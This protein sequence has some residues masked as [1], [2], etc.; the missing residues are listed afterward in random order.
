MQFVPLLSR[1]SVRVAI[2]VLWAATM[3]GGLTVFKKFMGVLTTGV[4]PPTSS[5]SAIAKAKFA[6]YFPPPSIQLTALVRSESGEPL[7]NG[8][9][10]FGSLSDFNISHWPDLLPHDLNTPL[11]AAAAAIS[12]ALRDISATVRVSC[13]AT[14]SSFWDNLFPSH[15]KLEEAFGLAVEH[16]LFSPDFASTLMVTTI[17]ACHGRPV[18]QT[19]VTDDEYCKPIAD[20][21]DALKKYA[22][23]HHGGALSVEGAPSLPRPLPRPRPRA[24]PAGPPLPALPAA[25]PAPLRRRRV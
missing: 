21:S 5:D 13:N 9:A 10:T 7:I 6:D 11:T 2:V 16:T 15:P 4:S 8:S 19:C 25:P 14:F 3:I 1:R 17:S 20:L 23:A 22:D 18:T 12:H 24:L